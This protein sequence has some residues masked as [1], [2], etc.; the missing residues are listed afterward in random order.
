MIGVLKHAIDIIKQPNTPL[1]V[2]LQLHSKLAWLNMYVTN[3][4][5]LQANSIIRIAGGDPPIIK[6]LKESANRIILSRTSQRQSWRVDQAKLYEQFV[7]FILQKSAQQ[8][9]GSTCNNIKISRS[10]SKHIA[11]GLAYLE[12]DVTISI[13]N[14]NIIADAKYKSH[15]YNINSENVDTLKEDFRHDLH[16]VLA[17][18]AFIQSNSK[19]A[20]ILYPAIG[21]QHYSQYYVF[22]RESVS[23]KVHLI[24]LPFQ[25][26]EMENNIAQ[27]AD[28]LRR[29]SSR[30]I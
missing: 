3:N 18:T 9:G 20:L 15:L 26:S 5:H 29:I 8:C 6:Q 13:G 17:Y 19:D 11:W 25:V 21:Y 22:P 4:K 23:I 28:L 24:G 16:Q 30:E 14:V 7:Q 12:P 27:I 10:D 1:S 2:K